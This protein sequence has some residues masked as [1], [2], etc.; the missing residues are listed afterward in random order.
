MFPFGKGTLISFINV[1]E[2]N[3]ERV[4]YST[5]TGIFELLKDVSWKVLRIIN[6]P[7]NNSALLL[8]I[9]TIVPQIYVTRWRKISSDLNATRMLCKAN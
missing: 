4:E 2:L 8:V 3:V 1:A 5:L 9:V 7:S 6:G